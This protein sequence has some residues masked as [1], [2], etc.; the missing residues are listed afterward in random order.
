MCNAPNAQP[1]ASCGST[2]YCST[3][4]Q[5]DDQPIHDLLCDAYRKHTDRPDPSYK[6]AIFFQPQKLSPEL[7]WYE[8]AAR[9]KQ[10]LNRSQVVW[11]EEPC[12]TQILSAPEG[13]K[14]AC[15]PLCLNPLRHRE[16]SHQITIVHRILPGEVPKD[17][18]PNRS[19]MALTK[20]AVNSHWKGP[21]II[22][23]EQLKEKYP[24]SYEDVTMV[25]FRDTVDFLLSY[26]NDLANVPELATRLT[27]PRRAMGVLVRPTEGILAGREAYEPYFFF[28]EEPA[29]NATVTSLISKLVDLPVRVIPNPYLPNPRNSPEQVDPAKHK[30]RSRL[31]PPDNQPGI[32]LHLLDPDQPSLWLGLDPDQPENRSMI[33]VREDKRDVSPVEVEALCRYAEMKAQPLFQMPWEG[34][35]TREEILATV[36]REDFVNWC[37]GKKFGCA[38]FGFCFGLFP[39][40]PIR[41]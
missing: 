2:R 38:R 27:S 33:V 6:R 25:D 35:N 32:Y 24:N 9:P 4:C 7:I 41:R 39:G 37:K 11:H 28:R 14:L 13:S 26:E 31:N 19:I 5:Q 17:L 12:V 30:Q 8:I 36:S 16:L 23:K 29:F 15:H 1:C 20:G 18:T 3:K 40:R 21:V 22:L 10:E 34:G